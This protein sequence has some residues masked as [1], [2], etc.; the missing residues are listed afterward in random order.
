MAG[1]RQLGDM[2]STRTKGADE[3]NTAFGLP[4]KVVD[5]KSGFDGEVAK[6]EVEAGK[7]RRLRPREKKGRSA[8]NACRE[9]VRYGTRDSDYGS[10]LM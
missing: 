5:H 7:N 9:S 3:E 1:K 6:Q 4:V 2:R 10:F 8:R